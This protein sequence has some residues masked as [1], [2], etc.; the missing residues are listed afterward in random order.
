MNCRLGGG[1]CVA[2]RNII[3]QDV[4]VSPPH[5]SC[6]NNL[7]TFAKEQVS[8]HVCSCS[9]AISAGEVQ[10]LVSLHSPHRLGPRC[11][12]PLYNQRPQNRRAVD[13]GSCSRI[14]RELCCGVIVIFA[15][16]CPIRTGRWSGRLL[17]NMFS[18]ISSG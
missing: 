17:V 16:R 10:Q 11:A 18:R 4:R 3:R 6:L 13:S 7:A 5:R 12:D 1:W 2:L 9:R 8:A 14:F 15:R